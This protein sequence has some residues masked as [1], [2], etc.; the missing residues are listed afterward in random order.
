MTEKE[1]KRRIAT[2]TIS[3]S[4]VMS[5][6]ITLLS[7]NADRIITEAKVSLKVTMDLITYYAFVCVCFKDRVHPYTVNDLYKMINWL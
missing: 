7:N 1:R 5:K 2:D 3:T 6:T 4:S